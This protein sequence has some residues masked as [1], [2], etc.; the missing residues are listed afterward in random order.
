LYRLVGCLIAALDQPLAKSPQTSVTALVRK[1]FP[2]RHM[3]AFVANDQ[4]VSLERQLTVMVDDIEFDIEP[5]KYERYADQFDP[6]K[7]DRKA[8]RKRK[9]TPEAH[10]TFRKIDKQKAEIA[11]TTAF[12]SGVLTTYQPSKY[13]ATWLLSSLQGFYAQSLITDVLAIVKGGKE[14]SVYRCQ[15]DHSTGLAFMAAKVYRPRMF[16]SLSND[17]M[18]REGRQLLTAE[19]RAVKNSD[20]RILRAVGKKSAFGEQV[21]HTSWLM[22]EYTTL[23]RLHRAGA[24]VPKPM[25]TTENAILMTYLGDGNIAAPPLCDVQL[26]LD[27]AAALFAEVLRNIELMLQHDMIHGDLSA[28]NILYWEGNITLIDFPQVSNSRTNSN[29]YFILQRDITRVCEY[30]AHQGIQT[31]ALNIMDRLWQRYGHAAG[32]ELIPE[33]PLD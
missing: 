3:P 2:V 18:Y 14:A 17:Q 22:H 6:L 30:F 7:T 16:R 9:P 4:A 15:A 32:P 1:G 5:D 19:G 33:E 12:D 28:Y 10:E 29:A 31:D 20:H 27:E 24:A 26:D 8:R 13:E 25:A 23:E 21:A 11:D